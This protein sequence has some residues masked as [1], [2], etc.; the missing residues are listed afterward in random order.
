MRALP[1]PQDIP[2]MFFPFAVTLQ[3]LDGHVDRVLRLTFDSEVVRGRVARLVEDLL[4]GYIARNKYPLAREL[5]PEGDWQRSCVEVV[6]P[7]S[8]SSPRPVGHLTGRHRTRVYHWHGD[9]A[10]LV[11]RKD[12]GKRAA[13]FEVKYGREAK[14][15][16][17]QKKFFRGILK[18]PERYMNGLG[19]ARV[20]VVRCTEVNTAG[21]TLDVKWHEYHS[22]EEDAS[23]ALP[24]EP[25]ASLGT[26]GTAR[27]SGHTPS[28]L[29]P[30]EP[31]PEG[32]GRTE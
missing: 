2:A 16:D 5:F 6:W 10:L 28:S 18:E 9:V 25:P 3:T 13:I 31:S 29:C 14:P 15:S 23:Q 8:G 30:P 17:A 32:A 4:T 11:H 7:F 21:A 24:Q 22:P 26:V 20:F 27:D 19:A 1:L 12:L